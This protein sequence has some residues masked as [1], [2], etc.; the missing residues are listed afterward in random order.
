MKKRIIS[1]LLATSMAGFLLTGCGKAVGTEDTQTA[2]STEKG[3]EGTVQLTFWC[4][5]DELEMYQ[6]MIDS[7][8]EEHKGEAAIEV[9]YGTVSVA[10]CKDSLLSDVN[11]GA[12]VFSLADDQVLTLVASGV[13]DPV[14][15]QEDVKNR[16]QEGA[17]DAATVDGQVYAYPI[18]ADNGYFL[19][20]D[21][22]YFSDSDVETLDRILEICEENG[23][24]FA[25][26]WSSGW[27]LYSFFGNT[28][29]ELG[30]NDDGLTNYC[31]W[32]STENSLQ[33][34]DVAQAM[35]DIAA[36]PAF[37]NRSDAAAAAQEG[38]AIA[39][40]SGVWDIANVKAVY[41]DN[42]GA[43]K[44]PTYTCAG[45]QIQMASF[46]GYRLM[47]VNSYSE[48]KD[49]AEK[50]A[51]YLTNEEN[52]QTRFEWLECGPANLNVA[53][54]EAIQQIPALAA[55][56]D[57]SQY[58]QLQEVGSAYWSPV[59]EFGALMAAGNPDG[60]DL[61]EIMDTMVN[62]ITE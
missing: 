51:D 4:D 2:F 38:S 62:T 32:N 18:T 46:T 1:C 16:N 36:S 40:V 20:Y 28:G 34:V 14:A 45:Q 25:M 58:G 37:S 60:A 39:F 61:Q 56:L 53:A 8:I 29:L 57:Q 44:L 59:A 52:Q 7:F 33:G 49:W 54:S 12:D 50:L 13:L 21:K 23:K 26:D 9:E 41:G 3:Q 31:N 10:D 48:N 15:D 35:L 27:Y 17:V 30:L 11:N 42:Y 22:Q 5:T 55:V 6:Q 19:Y 24:T 47:G 43:C